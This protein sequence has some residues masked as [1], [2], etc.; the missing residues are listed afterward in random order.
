MPVLPHPASLMRRW[1]QSFSLGAF[2]FYLLWNGWW[3]AKWKIPP[4]IF[5]SLT[6][7]PCPT[8]GGTRSMLALCRG[9]WLQSLLWNPLTLVY[10]LLLAY[11][12]GSLCRQLLHRE[13]LALRPS[14]AWMWCAS[15]AVGWVAK[16]AIGPRYW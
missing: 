2:A 15:L 12:L 4:S 7:L 11:S 16:F 1:V 13:R 6:G 8:T 3:I 5:K 14:V 10:L 9:D